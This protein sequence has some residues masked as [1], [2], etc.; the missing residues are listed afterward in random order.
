M[1]DPISREYLSLSFA[2][3]RLF[4]GFI[5]AY[6]GPSEIKDAALAEPDSTPQQ[7]LARATA[8]SDQVANGDYPES[9]KGFLQSQIRAMTTV[10]RRLAGEPVDYVDE[11]RACFDIEPAYTP[12]SVFEAAIA[13]LDAL[14]TGGGDVR[15]RMIAWRAGYVI[16]NETAR[17]LIDLIEAETRHRTE[18]FVQLPSNDG[19]EVAFVADKPWS[20]YNW[21]LGDYRSRV[22]VNTDLPIHA[23][24]LTALIAH[25]GY[26]G[27]HTEHALKER[28]YTDDGLGEQALQLIN[29][30]ECLIS[31]GIATTAE[32]MIFTPDEL[33][34]FRRREVYAPAGI[35]GDPERELAIEEARRALGAVPC[36][37][38]LL[39]HEAGASEAE[40]VTYLQRYGLSTEAEARKRFSFVA[41]PLWRAYIFTYDVGHSL[42]SA[43]LSMDDGMPRN[44][45][46]RRLLTEQVTPS[47]LTAELAA[48]VDPS[49]SRH[50]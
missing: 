29:T 8:L 17:R 6:F 43:W 46:F 36:N 18:A 48:A 45:K 10:S 42:V 3:E 28:L 31:E 33:A 26:P 50:V 4:P 34:H 11:V 13:E 14:L 2:I 12:E 22:D 44:N 25:E 24:E 15:E 16:D 9:R 41:N 49:Q 32:S 40:V 35:V 37:A 47:Q 1:I 39:L 5:D 30:P 7:L 21:Y 27:H 19:V 20:G 38:A 23:H